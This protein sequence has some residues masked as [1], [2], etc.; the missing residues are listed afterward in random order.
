MSAKFRLVL[1]LIAA[2]IISSW[3]F[4]PVSPWAK[5]TQPA[6]VPAVPKG[7]Q[8]RLVQAIQLPPLAGYGSPKPVVAADPDGHVL[9]VAYGTTN[10]PFGSDML[11]WRSHDRGNTWLQ[12]VNLTNQAQEGEVFFDPWLETDRRG[13]FYFV[14]VPP[15]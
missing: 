6:P 7:A 5:V 11:L 1:V 15:L 4:Q 12:P 3:L 10:A 14:H 8:P 9:I 13:H 2:G